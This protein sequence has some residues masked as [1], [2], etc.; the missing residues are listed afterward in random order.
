MGEPID[1]KLYEKVKGMADKK[2]KSKTGIYKSS[3]IVKTYKSLGG[4]YKGVKPRSSGLKRWYKEKWVD[5]NRPIKKNNKIMDYEPCGR[6][7]V[8]NK[9]EKYPLC[10][11]TYKVTKQTPK[12]YKEISSKDIKKAKVDKAKIKNKGN[13]K[14]GGENTKKDK[15]MSISFI[16]N[17][18]TKIEKKTD[19]KKCPECGKKIDIDK[20]PNHIKT[21]SQISVKDVNK[22]VSQIIGKKK[23]DWMNGGAQFYGKKSDVMI[24]VPKDVKKWALYAFKLKKLGF[25]GAL[26]TGWKRAKQLA[27]QDSISIEDFRYMRNWYARHIYTSYP[28]FKKWI[29]AGKPKDKSWHDNHAILSWITWGANAGYKW[30]NS[31][32]NIKLLNEYFNKDYKK[33]KQL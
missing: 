1:K 10:R 26:E 27:T 32:K 3:W 20:L 5:L 13:I 15:R 16:L 19:K 7:S 12:I 2:F 22:Y 9:M 11:P 29:D 31:S 24:K 23:Y 8:N 4:L 30:V 18:E 33:I 14:F 28:G 21:H 6:S 17:P 25:E